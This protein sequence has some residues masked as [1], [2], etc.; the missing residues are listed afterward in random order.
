MVYINVRVITR[1]SKAGIAGMRDGAWLVRLNSS[2]VEGAANSELIRII[3]DALDVPRRSI[4]IVAGEHS[5]SK[6]IRVE[7][8]TD[9]YVSARFKI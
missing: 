1:A 3:S 6:R 8:V 9:E 2:P 4:S 7:G 5:R